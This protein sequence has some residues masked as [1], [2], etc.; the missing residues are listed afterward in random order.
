MDLQVQNL[1]SELVYAIYMVYPRVNNV[2][3]HLMKQTK[4]ILKEE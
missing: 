1:D 2:G 3:C 4:Q